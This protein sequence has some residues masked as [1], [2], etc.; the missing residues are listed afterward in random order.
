[1]RTF[2]KGGFAKTAGVVIGALLLILSFAGTVQA[3]EADL[4]LRKIAGS[5]RS[6]DEAGF[7]KALVVGDRGYLIPCLIE[8]REPGVTKAAV[9]DLGGTAQRIAGGS[10]LSA[11]IAPEAVE[12]IVGRDEVVFVEAAT[13]MTSK[14]DTARTYSNVVGVQDG[15]A[16]G[17]P[18]RGTNVVVGAVDDAL[19][20]GNDDFKD[21]NGVSR[22][23][24]VAQ[25]VGGS[26]VECTHS[27]VISGNCGITD[28]GQGAA[29]GTHVTG[30]AAGAD[31]TYTGVAPSADIMFVFNRAGSN[32]DTE[33]LFATAIIEG[34]NSIFAKADE[35]DKAAVVNLSLGTS[36]G[37][38][39]GTSLVEQGLDDLVGTKPGR[40]VVNAAGNEQAVPASLDNQGISGANVGGIHA[41]IEVPAGESRGWRIGVWN[42][43]L[44][45]AT[46]TRGTL[47]DVWLADGMKDN[48]Q[49]A[50]FAYA[51][52]RTPPDYAFPNINTTDDAS[53]ASGDVVFSTD[54]PAT[55]TATDGSTEVEI[56]VDSADARN[57]KP[58]ATVVFSSSSGFGTNLQTRWFDVVLRS[59][60]AACSGHMW[61]YFDYTST[62]DYLKNLS[63]AGHDVGNGATHTGYAMADGDSQYTTTIP[64][65]ANKVIAAGSFMPPKPVGSSSSQ[66]TGNDSTTYNQSDVTAPGGTGSATGDLSSFSSL[67]PTADGRTKP[68][69]VA[70]G[71]PII[72]TLARNAS[73]SSAIQVGNNHFKLEGTSMSSPHLAGVVA[74]LL[75]RNNTLTIDQ[76]RTALQTGADTTG[77][78]AKSPDPANSYGAGKVNAAQV[79]GSVVEDTSA[80]SGGGDTDGG[81]S[82]S[83]CSL[84]HGVVAPWPIASFSALLLLAM[85]LSRFG[86][87]S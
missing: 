77:M 36:V 27:S 24:Y 13:L 64:A 63:G 52:D 59:T 39:D 73:V 11:Y 81:S 76:V 31:A 49:V 72:S 37:A 67:G 71:E 82:S 56:D 19:D 68:D 8:S 35:L 79:L 60:G 16:L 53:F 43:P 1:M 87:R 69:V 78:T 32:A 9:E 34:V 44:A 83:N 7:S 70:P 21:S 3:G 47:A 58:H 85:G 6:D 48:C 29:H 61:L 18:Y 54:T 62:H 10:I 30:I 46:F 33:G 23:Q 38:H 26:L 42:G 20:Y 40:I 17:I 50:A 45:S 84:A 28:G 14:M 55:V 80:Y 41:M 4:I 22:V 12:A 66:W 25:T 86:R 2:R 65:T 75:E 51:K 74:L 57:N 5:A 15:S